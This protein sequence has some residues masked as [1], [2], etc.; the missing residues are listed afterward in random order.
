VDV[1]THDQLNAELLAPGTFPGR[2]TI[3]TEAAIEKLEEANK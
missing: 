2:L 3:Y 1:I